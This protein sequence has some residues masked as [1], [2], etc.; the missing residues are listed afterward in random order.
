MRKESSVATMPPNP[1]A[2]VDLSSAI[3]SVG[4]AISSVA[5]EFD[6]IKY[7]IEE[8]SETIGSIRVDSSI[9][10]LADV[11]ALSV[12]AKNG[13]DEDRALVVAKLKRRFD[14]IE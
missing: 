11:I 3:G 2:Q 6:S 10:D 13:T 9:S 8:M 14:D 12:I 1:D 5:D 4:Q 7:K